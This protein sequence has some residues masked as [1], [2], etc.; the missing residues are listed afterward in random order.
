MSVN[1]QFY[2]NPLTSYVEGYSNYGSF[3]EQT[4]QIGKIVSHNDR[5]RE[6]A[7]EYKE[8][9]KEIKNAK[10]EDGSIRYKDFDYYN[11]DGSIWLDYLDK[12]T[13]TKDAAKEDINQ[14][15]V[16]QNNAY[17]IGMITISTI[18]VTTFLVM[19]K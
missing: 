14:L 2:R 16:Q 7:K 13:T 19:R 11:E 1:C 5:I 6:V 18:I 9:K 8:K 17:I 10:N 15:I 3:D 12:K 4:D